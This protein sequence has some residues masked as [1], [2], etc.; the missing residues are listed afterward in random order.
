MID[1]KAP[2]ALGEFGH[3]LPSRVWWQSRTDRWLSYAGHADQ[4]GMGQIKQGGHITASV[5]SGCSIWLYLQLAHQH[6]KLVPP[7]ARKQLVRGMQLDGR[8]EP[9]ALTRVEQLQHTL[10]SEVEKLEPRVQ[11]WSLSMYWESATKVSRGML[12]WAYWLM[13]Y[14]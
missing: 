6:P 3:P 11:I 2:R 1:C 5:L 8:A 4:T 14:V 10:T 9:Q 7:R 12:A 13:T